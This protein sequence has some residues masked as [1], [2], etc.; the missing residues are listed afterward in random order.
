MGLTTVEPNWSVITRPIPDS[1]LSIELSVV[2]NP[3]NDPPVSIDDGFTVLEDSAATTIDVLGNDTDVEGHTLTISSVSSD[4]GGTL[5]VIGNQISYQPAAGFNGVELVTYTVD[6]GN[7]GTDTGTLTVNVRPPDFGN[8]V[9]GNDTI[10]NLG[11]EQT[12]INEPLVAHS[13]KTLEELSLTSSAEGPL[14]TFRAGSYYGSADSA[15]V[16]LLDPDTGQSIS[17]TQPL[18]YLANGSSVSLTS[19][20]VATVFRTT[21]SSID[22]SESGIGL[23]ITDQL[24][25]TVVSPRSIPNKGLAK[26]TVTDIVA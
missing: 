20:N 4:Q 7:G 3:V 12:L 5:A 13:S 23:V 2:L 10:L 15:T 6:D 14:V 17:I 26:P 18:Q 8:R 19:G 9:Q 25:S 1:E 11:T 21:E 16:M 24:G 22:N